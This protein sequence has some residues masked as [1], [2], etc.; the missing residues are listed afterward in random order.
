MSPYGLAKPELLLTSQLLL[1][2]LSVAIFRISI[3]LSR[4]HMDTYT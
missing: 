4:Q 1:G 2:L 3:K